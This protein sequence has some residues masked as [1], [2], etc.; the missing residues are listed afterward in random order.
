MS[1]NG[2]IP[3]IS[4]RR[5]LPTSL[6]TIRYGSSEKFRQQGGFFM[7]EVRRE[8]IKKFG[9]DA[10]D[11]ANSLYAGGLWVRSSMDPV[12]QDAAAQALRDGL[13]KFDGG[14]GWRDTGLSVNVDKDG[15]ANSTARR[16]AP[17]IPI[18]GRR[19]C[20]RKAR[21]RPASASPMEPA[22]PCPR[23]C[24]DAEAG[25]RRSRLRLPHARAW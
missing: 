8:L 18:G 3:K 19:S 13:T 24:G 2:Y 16:S 4:G 21:P 6:G 22:A 5:R 12:M 10:K 1:R 20:F 23:R 11:G 9:Q 14:R 25:C 17:A 15:R 7:E